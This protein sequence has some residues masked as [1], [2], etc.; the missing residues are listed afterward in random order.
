MK[1]GTIWK[2]A[3][4]VATFVACWLLLADGPQGRG[5]DKKKL[6]PDLAAVPSDASGFL[7]VRVADYFNGKEADELKQVTRGHP[8]LAAGLG[9]LER[10]TGL[11][12]PQIE[13]AVLLFP[14]L[15]SDGALLT[16][17]TTVKPVDKQAVLK[18]LGE[19]PIEKK[20]GT[21][22]Y[23]TG[24]KG[25]F[26]FH[27]VDD[28]TVLFG[29]AKAVHAYLE[30]PAKP[31]TGP[32]AEAL[33]RAADKH[34]AVVALDPAEIAKE[35]KASSNPIT[36]PFIPALEAKFGTVVIDADKEL[37]IQVHL[38][39]ANADQAKEGAKGFDAFLDFWRKDVTRWADDLPGYLK[40]VK[41]DDP[42]T[43]VLEKLLVVLK[44][45]QAALKDFTLKQNGKDLDGTLRMKAKNPATALVL[46]LSTIPRAKKN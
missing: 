41:K 19:K 44:E 1:H 5:Q 36:K 21:R 33:A 31:I 12:P 46:I 22:T 9:E 27:F 13:R 26:D 37:T 18:T 25:V 43:P 28:H 20:V 23:F 42:F 34:L 11:T 3:G 24:D 38:A 8:L 39:F 15:E 17:F 10:V 32:L 14:K 30:Q 40:E 6:P 45:E 4:S 2:M 7:A 16:I 35:T 29:Q